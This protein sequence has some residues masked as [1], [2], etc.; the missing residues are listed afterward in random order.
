[1]LPLLLT[2]FQYDTSGK[3]LNSLSV[4]AFKRLRKNEV[5]L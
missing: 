3:V 1:M 2:T 5:G 4:K